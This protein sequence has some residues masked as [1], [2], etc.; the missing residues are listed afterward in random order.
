MKAGE[1]AATARLRPALGIWLAFPALE[2]F[3]EARSTALLG[4]DPEADDPRGIVAH[5]LAVAALEVSNP[6]AEI[7]LVESYDLAL[8]YERTWHFDWRAKG[9]YSM[10]HRASLVGCRFR[11]AVQLE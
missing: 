1:T 11:T 5:V 8:G 3:S 4:Y 2:R 6:I 7:V 9:R 10:S